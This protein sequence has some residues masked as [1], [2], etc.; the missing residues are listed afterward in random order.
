MTTLILKL[1]RAPQM[2]SLAGIAKGF[3]RFVHAWNE[4]QRMARI[5][6]QRYPFSIE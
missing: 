5:A 6:Q 3:D 2:P 1:S 4:A